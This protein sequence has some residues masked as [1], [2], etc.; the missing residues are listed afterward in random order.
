M[1]K[2]KTR[3]KPDQVQFYESLSFALLSQGTFTSS[4]TWG[5]TADSWLLWTKRTLS[6]AGKR[7]AWDAPAIGSDLLR[8][9]GKLRRRILNRWL[10]V[11]LLLGLAGSGAAV[12]VMA[13]D[14]AKQT[15]SQYGAY[16][17]SPAALLNRTS[18]GITLTDRNGTL[19]YQ[20]YGASTRTDIHLADLPQSVIDA[21]LAAEDP[22]FYDHA[23]FSWRGTL[24][25]I[26]VD[27]QKHGKLQ[28]GSTITQQLIKNSLLTPE[29]SFQRK[30]QEIVLSIALEKK[31]TKNQILEMYLNKVY[32]GQGAQ[33]I[34]AAAQTYFHKPAAQLTLPESALL[35]GLPLAPSRLDPT[36][37]PQAAAARRSD[38]LALMQAGHRITDTE[39]AAAGQAPIV[40]SSRQ[41]VLRAPHFV[42]YVLDELRKQYGNDAVES[43]GMVV[44]TS[45]DLTKQASAEQIVAAQVARLA[46]NNAT[47]GGL[48]SL[49]PTTGDVLAMVGSIGYDTPGFGS[50]NVTT[51]RLQPGSS[52]KP[53]VYAAAFAGGW[54]GGTVVEDQP[55]AVPQPDGSVYR[56]NNYDGK[57]RGP[58]TL[59]RALANSLNIPALHV[60]EHVGL[61]PAIEFAKKLG[62]TTL[63]DSSQYGES[64]VLG[65][66][67][68]RPLDMA[69]A[70]A[71]FAT[72]GISVTPRPILSVHD[73]NGGDLTKPVAPGTQVMDARVAAMI[74]DILSD[75]TART[76]EFT[77]N[78]PLRL[79]R[80][81]AAKTGTTNDFRDN[82]TVGY[83]PQLV[84]AV[85]VGNN[86]H[87]K[88]LGVDGITGAAPIWHDYMEQAL[89]GQPVIPF[90][91]PAGL[92]QVAVCATDG[93]LANAWDTKV[94]E[95]YLQESV[96][97]KLCAT[98]PKPPEAPV[99]EGQ[100]VIV[101]PD[102][103]II[104]GQ[105]F[106]LPKNP[107]IPKF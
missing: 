27:A 66:A 103:I 3:S 74:T 95:W 14:A 10:V 73:K 62:I 105:H 88:M 34:E 7:I 86:N 69:S 26:Y 89:A 56:P 71:S 45:L 6:R 99:T 63:G 50:V 81:A 9:A 25:A 5:V 54:S 39:S 85:W 40:V 64:I 43:G 20:A 107:A 41:Q 60:L 90:V 61:V 94:L 12:G 51:S 58:V 55:M 52:F 48:V 84:T 57:F 83:T 4:E 32:Y 1:T 77:A 31:Y 38:V 17:A 78:S 93:G 82:W 24:R 29:K 49:D 47:N 92:V 87:S 30:F 21:T 11:A 28:G 8:V 44:K 70:Y 36:A 68:V 22:H 15:I 23:G 19:L 100:P 106:K 65:S 104:N 102:Y 98:R 35:A 67:E 16:I 42:F 97:T 18:T 37:F 75:N 96:P 76:E 53:L 79:S 33:G 46:G 91:H 2:R 80:P 72:G 101:T 13:Y 59:R